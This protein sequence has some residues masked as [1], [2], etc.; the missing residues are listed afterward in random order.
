MTAEQG[1]AA[2]GRASVSLTQPAMIK[3]KLC[4]VH[5]LNIH[6]AEDRLKSL[7]STRYYG[8]KKRLL[9]WIYEILKDLPFHTVLDGF[10]G[11]A[12][13]SLLFKAM[14]KAVTFHDAL[15]CNTIAAKALL[16]D[17][18]PFANSEEAQYFFD[19]IIPHHAFIAQTFSG[20]F[21][22]DSENEWLDGAVA[23]ISA[24]PTGRKEAL[25][26]CLFQACLQKRPFNLFHRAN[27]NLRTCKSVNQSFGNQTTWDT[28][29]PVLAKRAYLELEKAIWHSP[30]QSNILPSSDIS[31]LSSNYDL[32]YL[33]PPYINPKNTGDDY[34]RRYHFLEG[35]SQYVNWPSMIDHSYNNLQLKK[36]VHVTEW[37]SKRC[38]KDRLFSLVEK[39]SHSIVALSYVTNAFPSENELNKLFRQ[40]FR[41]VMIAKKELPHALSQGKKNE[42]IIIGLP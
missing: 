12:S 4:P 15:Q 33:D 26:Y 17:T 18:L 3:R 6:R 38:F 35:L 9:P 34:L 2:L 36:N 37:Q 30:V 5:D 27:L 11:T 19:E 7:P 32:V 23:A 8:S 1:N 25:Y 42:I 10:G 13:V 20:K 22:L 29:F 40:Q 24:Q 16:A 41:S 14:G 39:H 28:P 31:E 21:Y